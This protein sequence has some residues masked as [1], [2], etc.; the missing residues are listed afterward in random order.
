MNLLSFMEKR[1][2][3]YWANYSKP[4]I[5]IKET[6]AEKGFNIKH[7]LT[8]SSI[9]I[10]DDGKGFYAG[11]ESIIIAYQLRP[12]KEVSDEFVRDYPLSI[13]LKS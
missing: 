9:P 7:I 5:Q 3:I 13:Y 8:A 1:E 11:C 4:A 6:L 2:I 12:L 10:L